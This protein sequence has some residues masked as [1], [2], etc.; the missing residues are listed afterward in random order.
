MT[1]EVP[2]QPTTIRVG[3]V[4][5][6]AVVRDGTAAL[7]EREPDIEIVGVAGTLE[8][9][10]GLLA[11]KPDVLVVDIRLGEQNGFDFVRQLSAEGGPAVVILSAFDYPQYVDAALR[12]GASG[13]ILKT[14]P[15][16]NLVIAIRQV[17]A[18]GVAYSVRPRP[19]D[20]RRLSLRET[21]VVALVVEGRSNDEIGAR[22]GISAKTVE[23]H[24]TRIY[25]RVHVASRTE[26][27]T[28]AVREGWIEPV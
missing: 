8:S 15:F 14:D 10:T 26:L 25:D 27:A 3:V 13:Y 18:G 2:A 23:S 6:H 5:D 22:L 9:A 11:L 17:A 7:L 19:A 16:G 20:H 12:L 24:L 28:R 4:D 1:A 21:E